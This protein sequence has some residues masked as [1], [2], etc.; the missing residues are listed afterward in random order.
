MSVADLLG[1]Q[2]GGTTNIEVNDL[3]VNGTFT[4]TGPVIDT[5]LTLSGTLNVAGTTTLANTSV[6]TLSVSSGLSAPSISLGASPAALNFYSGV[7]SYT[8]VLTF[9]GAA[10]GLT[11]TTQMGAYVKIGQQVTATFSFQLAT[12]GSSTGSAAVSLPFPAEN[13]VPPGNVYTSAISFQGVTLDAGFT[14]VTGSAQAGATLDLHEDGSAEPTTDLTN[15]SFTVGSAISG[16]L[17]Y[18]TAT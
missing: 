8:P 3:I 15:T 9:G 18:F 16:T 5:N 10:V 13:L 14:V 1:P 12:V 2:S 11:Y 4:G 7:Q 17:T 6:T